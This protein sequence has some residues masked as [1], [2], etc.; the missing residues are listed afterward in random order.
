MVIN[1]QGKVKTNPTQGDLQPGVIAWDAA[2]IDKTSSINAQWR[3]MLIKIITYIAN[4]SQ[5]RSLRGI[6][7]HLSEL[8][9]L[10]INARILIGI[11]RGSPAMNMNFSILEYRNWEL[12]RIWDNFHT[13]V[14]KAKSNSLKWA[15]IC[16]CPRI[17]TFLYPDHTPLMP[18]SSRSKAWWDP[19]I[20]LMKSGFF[21]VIC[22]FK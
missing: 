2:N 5:C 15:L 4:A 1:I 6:D 19:F 14:P 7:R 3:S 22:R 12:K 13:N 20:W 8:I 10:G 17:V 11:N 18:M 16:Q 9:N 21:Y